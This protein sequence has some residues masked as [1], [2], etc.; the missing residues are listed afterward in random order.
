MNERQ[1]KKEIRIIK[2]FRKEIVNS[3]EK[4]ERTLIEAGICTKTMKLMERYK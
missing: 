2:K 3:K 4:A 1:L